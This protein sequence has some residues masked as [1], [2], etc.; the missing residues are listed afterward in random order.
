MRCTYKDVWWSKKKKTE[1]KS[2]RKKE[3]S[4]ELEK[5]WNAKEKKNN[6]KKKEKR[7]NK[8]YLKKLGDF[9]GISTHMGLFYAKKL[10]NHVLS[11]FI[12]TFFVLFLM[13]LFFFGLPT[14]LLDTNI[15]KTNPF[16]TID[17]T[18]RVTTSPTQC[19]PGSNYNEGVFH[20]SRFSKLKPH[21][22][23]HVSVIPKT[24][25]FGVALSL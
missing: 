3:L 18:I 21:H 12:F 5:G 10:V 4:K 14:V 23:I 22:Q 2:R 1:E 11:T 24:L 15:L 7:I 9:N 19:G 20:S 6:K 25:Y 13:S 8:T 17:R 16:S